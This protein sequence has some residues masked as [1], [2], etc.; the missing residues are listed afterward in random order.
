MK[1]NIN[2]IGMVFLFL[3]FPIVFITVLLLGYEYIEVYPACTLFVVGAIMH[4]VG[5][6]LLEKEGHLDSK[7]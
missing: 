2:L 1:V 5:V 6:V 4:M 3:G 7:E